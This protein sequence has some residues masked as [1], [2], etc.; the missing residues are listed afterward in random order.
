M[1]KKLYKGTETRFVYP[2]DIAPHL[3]DGWSLTPT[4]E[5][6]LTA[7]CADHEI[8]NINDTTLDVLRGIG[9]KVSDSQKVLKNNF[10][11]VSEAIELIPALAPYES[12]LVV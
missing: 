10:E 12:R 9:L 6:V 1:Q 11:S 8:I 2:V 7:E 5:F 3:A 4:E